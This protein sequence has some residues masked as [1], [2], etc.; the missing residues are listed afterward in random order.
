M[1][2]L[3]LLAEELESRP[4][5]RDRVAALERYLRLVGP[6]TG[7]LAADCLLGSP[8]RAPA[9]APARVSQAALL[10]AAAALAEAAGMPAWL[11]DAGR[12]A[13]TE[14][15]E[16]IALLLP[17]PEPPMS[18]D[19]VRATPADWLAAWRRAAGAG[20]GER[21]TAIAAAIARLDDA[22][23]RRWAVRAA[24]GLLRPLVDDWQ[25][26]RAW[27]RAYGLDPHRLAWAWHVLGARE[28][29]RPDA[30]A[31]RAAAPLPHGFTTLDEAPEYAHAGLLAHWR[32]AAL[33]A[34]PRWRGLR[35]QVV[36]NGDAL[37]V[38][39]RAGGLLNARLPAALVEPARWPDASVI[40]AVLIARSEAGAAPVADA[41]SALPARAAA[42]SGSRSGLRSTTAVPTLHLVLTDWLRLDGVAGHELAPAARR[43]RLDGRWPAW[44]P[45]AEAAAPAVFTTPT[46]EPPA[47]LAAHGHAS[48]LAAIASAGAELGWGGLVLRPAVARDDLVHGPVVV[49]ASV[50][51]LRA[52]LQYVPAEAL[53]ASAAAAA[54]LAGAECGF[55]LW[56][57]APLS[58]DERER[59][60]G[61]ALAGE[62]LAPPEVA[63]ALGGLRLLPLARLPIALPD[64]ELHQLHAWLRGHAGARFG[65]V[66][67][68]MPALVFEIGFTQSRASR[69]H[70]LGAVIDG[71]R[72]L[73]WLRDAAP[74]DAQLAADLGA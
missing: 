23:A 48:D 53:G 11:F 39:P 15:A 24:C 70:K 5:D 13:S 41:L 33:S 36:R 49:R 3:A 14:Q 61:A 66:H 65:G 4:A 55:A 34:E 35:V 40:E 63:P 44:R 19:G 25:W 16:A 59:A 6:D 56:S 28:H 26:Q 54:A 51:R 21:A 67:A 12:A 37:A 1:R 64:A 18:V 57:R 9:S 29:L 31:L 72:V 62:F 50:R 74:G 8:A 27:A 7:A 60:M 30:A 45:A 47:T 10:A 71:A 46:L 38:W 20:P 22:P 68:V 17:W 43:A 73:R 52:V 69:R 32:G 2:T 58:D 42:R